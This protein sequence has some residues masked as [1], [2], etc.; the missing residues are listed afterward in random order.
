MGKEEDKKEGL[1]KKLK[2]IKDK[3]EELLNAFSA[4]NKVSKDP[5]NES[6]YNYDSK[7]TF[8]EFYRDFKN[9]L[10]MSLDS[11]YVGMTDFHKLLNSFINT[12][13]IITD[14]TNNHKNKILSYVMPLYNNYSDAYRKN[15]DNKELTDEDKRKYHYKQFEITDNRD[16]RLKSTLKKTETKKLMKYKKHFGLK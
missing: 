11:K 13:K 10:K 15:Y 16:Q 2:N 5:K 1:L 7:H 6:N 3:N 8:H 12:H 9:F 4:T 14:E